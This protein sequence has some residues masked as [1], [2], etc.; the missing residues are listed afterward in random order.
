MKQLCRIMILCALLIGKSKVYSQTSTSQGGDLTFT[1]NEGASIVLHASTDHAAAYQW[2]RDGVKIPGAINKDYTAAAAGMYSVVAFNTQGCPSDISEPVKV[3]IN[4][5]TTPVTPA[6]TVV[7]LAVTIASSNV[8]ASPGDSFTYI[9]TANNKSPITGT[10]VQV[11]Y[12]LPDNLVYLPAPGDDAVKY[13][14]ATRTLIWSIGQITQNDPTKLVITVKVLTPGMVQSIVKI[15]GEQID[16]VLANNVDQSVQQVYPLVITNVFTPNGDG[17]NDTFVIPGLETYSDTELTV[18][19]R[20]GNVVYQKTNYK[21][22]W[23]GSGLV[24][25]TY[26]YVLRAK[27]KAGVWDTYKGYLTLLRTR[28]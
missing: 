11:K 27:N 18:I 7:D 15:K 24:E 17:V 20:W 10:G 6:D 2:Y 3:V 21:N 23:D 4:Q 22:D 14:I 12:V 16:P 25:G 5:Q 8:H 28:I 19:N 1:I 9:L 13:D 26:F